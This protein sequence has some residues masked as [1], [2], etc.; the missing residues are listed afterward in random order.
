MVGRL[1]GRKPPPVQCKAAVYEQL[2]AIIF[3]DRTSSFWPAAAPLRWPLISLPLV[4]VVPV[5][6]VDPVDVVPEVVEPVDVSSF[7]ED[8]SSRPVT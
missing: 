8:S 2:D 6:A 1:H 4:P 5:V 7:F 3:T